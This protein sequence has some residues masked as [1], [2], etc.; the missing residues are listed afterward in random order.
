MSV[1]RTGRGPMAAARGHARGG[2]GAPTFPEEPHSASRARR[3]G[4]ELSAGRMAFFFSSA[5][6]VAAA[7]TVNPKTEVARAQAALAV[8]VSAASGLQDVLRT[9]LGP[10]GTIKMLVSRV[11]DIRLTKDTGVDDQ[12]WPTR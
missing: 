7:K 9:N 3:A 11:G 2:P 5:A 6:A 8:N 10:K 4:S 12:P 1:R